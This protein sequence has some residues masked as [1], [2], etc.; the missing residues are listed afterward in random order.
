M[1]ALSQPLDMLLQ[2]SVC[3]RRRMSLWLGECQRRV[4]PSVTVSERPVMNGPRMR[5]KDGGARCK[6]GVSSGA[7]TAQEL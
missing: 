4:D 7:C 1:A 6:R 5:G 2:L 3:C